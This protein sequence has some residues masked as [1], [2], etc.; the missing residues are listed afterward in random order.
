MKIEILLLNHLKIQCYPKMIS[1][2]EFKNC[3]L[4][5]MIIFL[6]LSDH[7]SVCVLVC[8]IVQIFFV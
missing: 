2:N 8:L 4:F 1:E 6:F 3:M 5:V 7:L